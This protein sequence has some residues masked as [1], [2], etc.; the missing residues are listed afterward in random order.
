[1]CL[2]FAHFSATADYV[3]NASVSPEFPNGLH[4]KYLHYIAGKLNKD[5]VINPMP[6]ARRLKSL[7][8]GDIDIMVGLQQGHDPQGGYEYLEPSYEALTHTLFVQKGQE[9]LFQKAAD[10]REHRIASTIDASYFEDFYQNQHPFN[11]QVSS[12]KQKIELLRKGRV[13]A[14]IHFKESAFPVLTR[15]G[16][17]G[18]IVMASYQPREEKRYFVALSRSSHLYKQKGLLIKIIEEGVKK[19]DFE[20]IRRDHYETHFTVSKGGL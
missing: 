3:I 5:L 10:L 18:E 6:F 9:N 16:L 19:G 12:L 2:V 4:A 8:F 20:Q 11:I 13:K 14:F 17:K 1:M 7:K 15:M